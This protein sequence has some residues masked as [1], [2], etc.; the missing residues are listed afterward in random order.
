MRQGFESWCRRISTIAIAL[1]ILGC[2]SNQAKLAD[3]PA[4][5]TSAVIDMPPKEL[6]VQVKRVVETPP[7]SL[8]I[9]SEHEGTLITGYQSFR[10]EWHNARHWQERTR[11]AI[12]I[13]PDWNGP[14][15]RARIDVTGQTQHRAARNQTYDDAPELKRSDRAA[16]LLKQIR[17]GL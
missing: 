14:T 5:P 10:G 3:T 11:Y 12:Q 2:K 15:K 8:P 17:A 1:A 16:A 4:P 13:S 6:V 9:E 7:I